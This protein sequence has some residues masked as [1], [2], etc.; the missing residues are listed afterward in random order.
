[1]YNDRIEALT[2]L[3]TRIQ[4]RIVTKRILWIAFQY[5]LAAG[6]LT[7]LIWSRWGTPDKP[8]LGAVWQKHFIDGEPIHWGY[9][10]TGFAIFASAAFLTFV[11][12][13]LLVR[14]QAL[15]VTLPE[16]IRLG[17]IGLFYNS[18]LPG[19]VGGDIVKAAG[20]ARTQERRTVAV[21]TV[22][23]D[24]VIALWG[25]VWFAAVLG[26]VFWLS[27]AL[28]G[29]G[30]APAKTIVTI[31]LAIV[32]VSLVVWVVMG[33]LS[34]AKAEQFAQ[35][36]G[37]IPKVGGSASE[38]WRAV[39]LYRRRQ[40]WVWL[41]IGLSW[42]C[43]VGYVMAFYCTANAFHDGKTDLPT[44][45]QHFLIV[46]IGLVIGT[47]PLFPGGAGISQAGFGGLYELFSCPMQNG[48]LAS[49]IYY[50]MQCA[51]GLLGFVV[52]SFQGR[53]TGVPV[54]NLPPPSHSSPLTRH[55]HSEGVPA[56]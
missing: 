30:A 37:R 44:L 5:L 48:F 29:K 54:V 10:L 56:A 12:W 27:G 18:F 16:A 3:A 33:L 9:L 40:L 42:I 11:R 28:D 19:G 35:R 43:F 26:S 20:L 49:L 15:Q 23:M 51:A 4:D 31:F 36:L 46:P 22:L 21:A 7:Y 24:R 32:A 45:S 34:D 14:A 55:P 13:Y 53:N 17:L 38:M 41:T 52:Y 50:V 25:L 2:P 47:V 6:L 8:G 1:L 39:W